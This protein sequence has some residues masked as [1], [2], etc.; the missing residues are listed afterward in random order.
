MPKVGFVH[1]QQLVREG[2]LV[3]DG[4]DAWSEHQASSQAENEF[5]REHG[6]VEYVKWASRRR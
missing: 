6:F 2:H 3:K 4:R 5:I 1:A